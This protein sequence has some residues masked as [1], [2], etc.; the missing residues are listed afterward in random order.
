MRD[1][2]KTGKMRTNEKKKKKTEAV[3]EKTEREQNHSTLH[4]PGSDWRHFI[5]RAII[6]TN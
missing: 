2:K 6:S 1:T 5:Q 4:K 3:D